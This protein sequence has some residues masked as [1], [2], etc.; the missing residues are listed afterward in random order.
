MFFSPSWHLTDF[1]LPVGFHV[2]FI[3]SV[4]AGTCPRNRVS[5]LVK[6]GQF[7]MRTRLYTRTA[8][9]CAYTSIWGFATPRARAAAARRSR[10]CPSVFGVTD[11][12]APLHI[13]IYYAH[14]GAMDARAVSGC[15][16]MPIHTSCR[17]ISACADTCTLRVMVWAALMLRGPCI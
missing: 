10:F 5:W 6:H 8:S 16:H 12:A 4:C 7:P 15:A 9:G 11:A 1:T 13:G 2:V 3:E 17:G 14:R